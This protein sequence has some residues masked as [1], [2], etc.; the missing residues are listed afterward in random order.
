[1]TLIKFQPQTGMMN[2]EYGYRDL[3]DIFNEFWGN[4]L[5]SEEKNNHKPLVNVSETN[6]AYKIEMSIPGFNKDNI[7][8]S[9]ENNILT[10]SGE[11]KEKESK[12][13]EDSFICKE[14]CSSEFQRSFELGEQVDAEKI[15]A[16][17]ENGILSIDLPKKQESIKK[18]ARSI[19]IE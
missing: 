14:F 15:T 2:R 11:R 5:P 7:K 1:M 17:T 16:R 10:I 9:I 6:D 8:M 19:E 12:K 18:T 3:S 13:E 4:S